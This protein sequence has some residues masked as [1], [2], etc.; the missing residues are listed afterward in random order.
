MV[1][2]F[3]C[4]PLDS[5]KTHSSVLSEQ[6]DVLGSGSPSNEQTTRTRSPTTIYLQF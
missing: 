2:I 3:E 1:Y 6:I 5:T 4:V